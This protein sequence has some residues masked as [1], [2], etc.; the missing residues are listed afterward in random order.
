MQPEQEN[1]HKADSTTARIHEA[2]RRK[3]RLRP[4]H[5][6]RLRALFGQLV[7]LHVPLF[8][9]PLQR[10]RLAIRK[11]HSHLYSIS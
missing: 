1:Q 3:E 5:A 7:R 9:P 11:H 4:R 10:P 8:S 2:E 6:L